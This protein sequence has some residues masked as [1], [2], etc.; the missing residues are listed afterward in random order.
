M[1]AP[2]S[3]VWLD[4]VKQYRDALQLLIM[5]FGLGTI[6]VSALQ[7]RNAV[8]Q[9]AFGEILAF[10]EA[11]EPEVRGYQKAATK[12]IDRAAFTRHL[13][14]TFN[15]FE[16]ALEHVN[17]RTMS[18]GNIDTIGYL[19]A[20]LMLEAIQFDVF[21]ACKDNIIKAHNY[22]EI[23][24]FFLMEFRRLTEEQRSQIYPVLFEQEASLA[25][26]SLAGQLVRWIKIR[27]LRWKRDFE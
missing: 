24:V 19:V 8:G 26:K 27:E 17:K 2:A 16:V 11:L 21:T 4:W 13:M 10:H 15:L 7:L 3:P 5:L 9:R 18:K 22:V 20:N 1:A 6:V 12:P 25:K 14:K 23:R